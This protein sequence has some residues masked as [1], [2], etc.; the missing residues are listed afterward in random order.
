MAKCT[1]FSRVSRTIPSNR[2]EGAMG[3]FA[4]EEDNNKTKYTF[5]IQA[6]QIKEIVR[7]LDTLGRCL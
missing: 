5:M 1:K 6:E 2:E 7:R 4:K 3:G